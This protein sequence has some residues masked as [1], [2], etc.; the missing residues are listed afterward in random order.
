MAPFVPAGTQ[1]NYHHSFEPSGYSPSQHSTHDI[2]QPPTPYTGVDSAYEYG[3]GESKPA[4]EAHVEQINPNRR[5]WNT[6]WLSAVTLILFALAS[7]AFLAALLVIYTL[8]QRS[9]GFEAGTRSTRYVWKYIPIA[10]KLIHDHSSMDSEFLLIETASHPYCFG[11]VGSDVLFRSASLAM[12]KSQEGP[13]IRRQESYLG[14]HLAC[15]AR[16][17]IRLSEEQRLGCGNDWNWSSFA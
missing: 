10:G 15:G 3:T 8:S 16:G 11:S 6:K 2:L 12:A 9:N 17:Y 5:P 1:D 13:C 7:S 14:L 4:F